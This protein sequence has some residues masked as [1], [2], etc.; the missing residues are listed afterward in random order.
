MLMVVRRLLDGGGALLGLGWGLQW[1]GKQNYPWSRAGRECSLR[2]APGWPLTG[3]CIPAAG[4]GLYSPEG[5]PG[6]RVQAPVQEVHRVG[7]RARAL[8][9]V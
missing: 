5:D 9:T 8:L 7:L 2:R 3:S 4:P 1:A 6:A